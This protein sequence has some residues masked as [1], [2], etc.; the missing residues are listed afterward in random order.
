MPRKK[1]PNRDKAKQ[2][3][4]ESGKTMLLK[5]IAKELDLSE[6]QIRKWKYQDKWDSESEAMNKVTLP[7]AKSNVTNQKEGKSNVRDSQDDKDTELTE[8]QVVFVAEYLTDFNATRAAIAAGYS[9]KSARAIGYENL[10]KPD[11][12][13]EIQ[14]QTALVIQ[15]LGITSQRVLLEYLKIAFANMTDYVSFGQ[16][17]VPALSELGTPLQNKDGNDIAYNVSYVEFKQS[18]EVDGTLISEVKKGRDGISIKL[19]DKMKALE[20]L[21]KYLDL[22]PDKH[23]RQIEEEKLKLDKERLQLEKIKSGEEQNNEVEDDG[24]IEALS[25]KASEVW[26]DYDE[27]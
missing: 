11:I 10:T 16:R 19:H 20:K 12:Q 17:E 1:S 18:D 9:K 25:G 14:R 24:F 23:K 26:A 13:K 5:D 6:E 4:L 3:W 22:L 8:R 27:E 15:N 7:N 21:E 2:M